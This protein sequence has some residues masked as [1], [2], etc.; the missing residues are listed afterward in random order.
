MSVIQVLKSLLKSW[1]K[2]AA[3]ILTKGWR[4][5]LKW[6][7]P[8]RSSSICC[9]SCYPDLVPFVLAILN[10]YNVLLANSDCWKVGT[11]STVKTN[12][13]NNR[14]LPSQQSGIKAILHRKIL[15]SILITHLW[16][17]SNE[18][19]IFSSFQRSSMVNRFFFYKATHCCCICWQPKE[20]KFKTI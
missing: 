16:M 2:V 13:R 11:R 7:Q 12:D 1:I 17:F 10:C 15:H 3:L 6:P 14:K 4:L 20:I 5:F 18:F 9:I 8:V 19:F